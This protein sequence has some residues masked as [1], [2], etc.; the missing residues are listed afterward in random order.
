MATPAARLPMHVL[1]LNSGSSSLKFGLYALGSSAAACLLAGQA[2]G[3]G[4]AT[5]EL[6][7]SDA[8][9]A[10]FCTERLPLPDMQAVV[11]RIGRLLTE[12]GASAPQAIGH[13]VVHGGPRCARTAGWTPRCSSNCKPPRPSRRCTP[14]RRWRCIRAAQQQFPGMPQVAC[15]DTV[16]HARLPAVAR[17]LPLA[18]GAARAR[19]ATLWLPWA[20][21]RVDRAATDRGA[22]SPAARQTAD[23]PSGQRCQRHRGERWTFDR[24]QHGPDAERRPDHG[25]PQR[26]S[27]SRRADLPGPRT[28]LRRRRCSKT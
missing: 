19:P 22:A 13:R 27:R 3:V 21:L 7:A 18:A 26:R 4:S 6:Q 23:C 25:Q 2:R 14:R 11:D 9:G 8:A 20:V 5:S 1:A 10:T 28:R 12:R 17:T 24:H 16:F 15:F